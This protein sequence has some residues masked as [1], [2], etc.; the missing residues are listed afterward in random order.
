MSSKELCMTLVQASSEDKVSKII[1]SNDLLKNEKN[2][3][4]FSNNENN[5]GTF[6]NQQ[7]HPV[8]ALTE[9]IVNSIDALLI[10]ECRL[11][12]IDPE[13]AKAPR[14]MHEAV[15][16][17]FGIANGNFSE[18]DDKRRREIAK[19]IQVI[20]EGSKRLPTII[21]VDRGEGQ[22]PKEFE[23]TFLAMGAKNK[24]KIQ[25]VQGKFHMGGTGALPFCGT[26]HYQLILSRRHPKLLSGS[27]KDLWGFTLLRY[28]VP[29]G[30]V[31]SG[32]FEY[33]TDERGYILQFEGEPLPILPNGEILEHGSFIK[34][35][36]Y[37]L[38]RPSIIHRDLWRELNRHLFSPA[39]PILLFENRDFEK[40]VSDK[41]LLGNK[42]RL[43]VDD[44]KLVEDTI[45]IDAKLGDFGLCRVEVTILKADA[46]KSDNA[47]REE[48]TTQNHAIFFTI[49]GQTH[50]TI[51]R[52]FLKAERKAN[53]DYLADYMIV[54]VDVT[55]IPTDIRDHAFM[56]SRDRMRDDEVKRRVE[57]DLA[58][59]LRK[60]EGLRLLNQHRRERAIVSSPK[61]E[62][63]LK[64]LLGK[65]IKTNSSIVEI[66]R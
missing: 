18:V 33:C 14:S 29:T 36:D 48:F 56:G 61:D 58:Q 30:Y 37:R 47:V 62:E 28:R 10:A 63:F 23:N 19:N 9:K 7:S 49:N 22:N 1:E 26:K 5:T 17:F 57:E 66:L 41:P 45:S 64:K 50:S 3:T 38:D 6:L 21:V 46:F 52:S 54:H 60:H 2:W 16:E 27:Q 42:M 65:L 43:R 15:E 40:N 8:A 53:L 34:M 31:R 55:H 32:C 12:N 4:P 25:F 24:I 44:N 13:S 51:G 20:A 39:L 35:Y 11:R 59:E